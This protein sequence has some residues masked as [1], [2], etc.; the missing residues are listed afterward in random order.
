MDIR[1]AWREKLVLN[2][3]IWFICNC[4]VFIIAVFGA[5][6]GIC[7]TEHVFDT[8]ELASLFYAKSKQHVYFDTG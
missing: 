8:S 7:P 2:L 4:A 6:T 3:L 1:Q 5:L